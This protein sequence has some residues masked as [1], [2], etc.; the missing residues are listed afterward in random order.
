MVSGSPSARVEAVRDVDGVAPGAV[1]PVPDGA[2][3]DEVDFVAE[4]LPLLVEEALKKTPASAEKHCKQN[5]RHR[6]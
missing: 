3:L 1:V 2:A 6:K 5:E 4:G